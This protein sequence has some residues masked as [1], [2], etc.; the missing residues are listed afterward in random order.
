M[1]SLIYLQD[2]FKVSWKPFQSNRHAHGATPDFGCG[3]E[4]G[5]QRGDRMRKDADLYGCGVP[6]AAEGDDVTGDSGR[7]RC[8]WMRVISRSASARCSS[9]REAETST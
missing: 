2:T 5:R 8:S 9:V 1:S 4:A 7:P 3:A 6:S